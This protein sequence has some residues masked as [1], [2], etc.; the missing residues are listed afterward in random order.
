M[1][2]CADSRLNFQKLLIIKLKIMFKNTK[3]LRNL[4]YTMLV[5]V[6]LIGCNENHRDNTHRTDS[7]I[8]LVGRYEVTENKMKYIVYREVD[9]GLFIINITKDSLEMAVY[10]KQL[11]SPK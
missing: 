1:G 3:Q 10:R 7:G 2:G 8:Y 6:F 11:V 5:A 4:L 9:G